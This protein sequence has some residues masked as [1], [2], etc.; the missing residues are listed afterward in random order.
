MYKKII[1]VNNTIKIK[2]GIILKRL[3]I[4]LIMLLIFLASIG[5]GYFYLNTR[6]DQKNSM[7][8]EDII[9]ENN[10]GNETISTENKEEKLSPNAKVITT[11]FYKECGHEIIEE[12]EIDKEIVNLTKKELEDVYKDYEIENFSELQIS[13][14]KEE[15]GY[16]DEHYCIGE[17]KGIICVYKLNKEGEEE[18]YETTNIL[19]EYLPEEEKKEIESKK[20]ILGKEELYSI[21]ENFES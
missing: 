4:F 11:C 9:A 21:L 7:S 16:C 15:P 6:D 19:M 5:I 12:K 18:L 8:S 1:L 10:I 17:E 2:G 13:L 14:Y 3:I 20:E